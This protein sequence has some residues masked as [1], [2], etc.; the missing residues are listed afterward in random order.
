[1][2][3]DACHLKKFCCNPVQQNVTEVSKRLADLDMVVDKMHFRN[4]VDRWCKSNCNPYDRPDLDGVD[5]EVCEQ[6]FAWLT[7]YG[8]ITRHMNQ[9]RFLFYILNL[10][11]LRNKKVEKKSK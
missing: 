6:T 7:R 11:E 3:D 2:Y 9:D 5:T 4:H 10:C 8:R 1:M